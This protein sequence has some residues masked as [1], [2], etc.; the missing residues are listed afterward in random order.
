MTQ[1]KKIPR[2]IGFLVRFIASVC[3]CLK[4]SSGRLGLEKQDVF[5]NVAGPCSE[6]KAILAKFNEQPPCTRLPL[7][8]WVTHLCAK[9][10]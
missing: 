10:L 1:L 2:D 8:R 9:P 4:Y 7:L 5:Q 6:R 3:S